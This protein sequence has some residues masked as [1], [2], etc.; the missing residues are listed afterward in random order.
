MDNQNTSIQI[1]SQKFNVLNMNQTAST[2]KIVRTNLVN[3]ICSSNFTNTSLNGSPFTFLQNVQ[4]LTVF[5]NCPIE[6]SSI[7]GKNINSFTCEK[8]GSNK[9]VF[10]VVKNETQLQNQFSNLQNCGASV[11]V[12]VSM[13]GT[14]SESGVEVVQEGFDVKYD[15]G[16][17]WSS[18]C[19]VCRESGGTCGTNQND[20]SQFSCYCP[21]GSTHAAKCSAHKSMHSFFSSLFFHIFL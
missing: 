17:G 14:V 4:N 7:I 1:G 6:S 19:E 3:D 13:D 15:E 16:A 18:E 21:G 12:Q 5:Y 11:Q 10:Y 9:H 8:N 20:S 2:M